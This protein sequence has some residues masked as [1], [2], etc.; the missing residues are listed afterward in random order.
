[1]KKSFIKAKELFIGS[2]ISYNGQLCKIIE[3]L[4]TP[5]Y[6]KFCIRFPSGTTETLKV[7][8]NAEIAVYKD[9]H[10]ETMLTN[11]L[12]R[13]NY[14]E[15]LNANNLKK[16][17]VINHIDEKVVVENV[18]GCSIPDHIVVNGKTKNESN[19][20]FEISKNSNVIVFPELTADDVLKAEKFAFICSPFAGDTE[21]NI[22]YA[23]E[24]CKEAVKR[25]YTPIA[26]HLYFPQFLDD[27]DPE[28]REKGLILGREAM[29]EKCEI[30]LVGDKYGIS[31]GMK[32]D[33]LFAKR[34]GIPI[35]Y[36]NTLNGFNKSEVIMA[37]R[38]VLGIVNAQGYKLDVYEYPEDS[39]DI[40]LFNLLDKAGNCLEECENLY[41]IVSYL[42]NNAKNRINS[43]F[44]CFINTPT[45][46]DVLTAI[47]APAYTDYV[48]TGFG[49]NKNIIEEEIEV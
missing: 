45:I 44:L 38:L 21:R 18:W 46:K 34:I 41:Q 40:L 31:E 42:Q 49:N 29:K 24:C 11:K 19:Y 8:T 13:I 14:M 7:P 33:L 20:S 43:E 36:L 10:N 32:G 37:I 4:G 22:A 47:T 12:R 6:I 15:I 39:T 9:C 25:G 35:E 28:Q 17:M 16:G 2:M 30:V 48:A 27:N 3:I 1:M 23:I 26:P 5:E